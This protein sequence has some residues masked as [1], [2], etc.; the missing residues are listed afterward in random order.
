M[1]NA[2]ETSGDVAAHPPALHAEDGTP[3]TI[4][5][6]ATGPKRHVHVQEHDRGP[7]M[8][9]RRSAAEGARSASLS[10]LLL[11]LL[12]LPLS[13]SARRL[14]VMMP[15]S[16]NV[17][18]WACS[19]SKDRHLWHGA[20]TGGWKVCDDSP[21]KIQPLSSWK[22]GRKRVKTVHFAMAPSRVAVL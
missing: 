14:T 15:L 2:A 19:M 20:L 17:G 22:S 7:T 18:F 21:R 9:N 12:L 4:P 11:L 8:S 1:M 16:T 10:L 3:R 6:H 5:N 13:V